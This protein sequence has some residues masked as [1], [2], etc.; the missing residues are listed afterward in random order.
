MPPRGRDRCRWYCEQRSCPTP[1]DAPGARHRHR[2]HE[3]GRDGRPLWRSH[4]HH[5]GHGG[6]R[7]H[8]CDHCSRPCGLRAATARTEKDEPALDGSSGSV[9]DAVLAASTSERGPIGG[10]YHEFVQENIID[11]DNIPWP[12]FQPCAPT[13][14][15]IH[16]PKPFGTIS[17]A[18]S[19]RAS[20]TA[21]PRLCLSSTVVSSSCWSHFTPAPKIK[22][23]FFRNAAARLL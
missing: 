3:Y 21:F 16:R 20:A 9:V 10:S 18:T 1:G 22:V 6:D 15:R 7:H 12:D 14:L 13:R 5:L 19:P 17:I 4:K 2:C 8:Q 11:T 23:L